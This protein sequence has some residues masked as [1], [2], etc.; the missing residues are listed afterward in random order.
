VN[1]ASWFVKCPRGPGQ[2]PE[3]FSGMGQ[4]WSEVIRKYMEKWFL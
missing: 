2:L 1:L 3:S 4:S